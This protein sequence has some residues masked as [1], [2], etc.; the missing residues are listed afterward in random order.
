VKLA[1]A[2]FLLCA[3]FALAAWYAPPASA[4]TLMSYNL[5]NLFDDVRNGTEYREFDPGK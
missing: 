5:Q 4:L 3:F 1:P 2:A